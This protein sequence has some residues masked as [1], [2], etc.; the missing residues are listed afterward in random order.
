MQ[1][2]FS[3]KN[4]NSKSRRGYDQDF[5]KALKKHSMIQSISRKGNCWDNAVAES[6]SHTS[7]TQLIYP[8]RCNNFKKAGFSQNP[9]FNSKQNSL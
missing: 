3:S 9:A 6:F 7:K 5:K 4:M 8:I 2:G 1:V